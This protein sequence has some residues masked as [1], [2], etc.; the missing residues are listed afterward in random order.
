MSTYPTGSFGCVNI[1]FPL[2]AIGAAVYGF[3]VAGWAGVL[4]GLVAGFV[5]VLLLVWIVAALAWIFEKITKRG[6]G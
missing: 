2:A 1:I 3:R 5:G 6:P 4:G